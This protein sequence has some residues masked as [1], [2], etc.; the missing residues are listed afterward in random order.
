[1]LFPY[2]YVPHQM[3]KMQAFIDFIFY[4]VWCKAPS[5]QYGI[6]LFA[7]NADLY[8]LMEHLVQKDLSGKLNGSAENFYVAV[9]EIYL[10][11]KS[12][13]DDEIKEYQRHFSAN[14]DIER[15]CSGDVA[16][17][18]IT[19]SLLDASKQSLNQK[20]ESFFKNLYSSGFLDLKDTAS[21]IGSLRD[22]Y[23]SFVKVN[24]EGICPFCGILPLDGEF[25]PTREAFDHYLPK[26]KYPFNSI[27]LKNLAPSCNKCNSGNKG[28]KDPLH[29]AVGKRRKAFYPFATVHS[30]IDITVSIAHKNWN[31]LKGE[32]V[33]ID[34]GPIS[35]A[36]EI[37]TWKE[38]FRVDQRY[39]AK[40]C[41]KS[42]GVAWLNRV[43]D[44]C[45]NYKL[46]PAEMLK[47][48]LVTAAKTPWVET[49]F[50]KKAFL[51][52]CDRAGLFT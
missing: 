49:R 4:E 38:L 19:F 12:L 21:K 24:D 3:E 39:V 27:N 9:N 44:E 23:K 34:F 14:N 31:D 40:C 45:Q 25:D 5:T 35:K 41:N 15:A 32:D 22:Y 26:S 20:L 42:G 37:S 2:T 16:C 7:A 28:D 17:I 50:L 52:G 18:P 13:S 47:A 8:E 43:F 48:E 29:D 11:F 46:T 36:D 1:M 30:G 33:A 10:E 51:E 6:H